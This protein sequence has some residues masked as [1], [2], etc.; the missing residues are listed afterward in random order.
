MKNS[1]ELLQEM[2]D[3]PLS[4]VSTAIPNP[5]ARDHAEYLAEY[6]IR[7]DDDAIVIHLF[8]KGSRW[9]PSFLVG[10]RLRRAVDGLPHPAR[11]DY[12]PE[13]DSFCVVVYGLGGAPDPWPAIDRFFQTFE[14]E[15]A[16]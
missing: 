1:D 9:T 12:A 3:V 10:D 16:S 15:S 8:P 11:A 14:S 6:G 4:A 2:P 13:L 5:L 7:T